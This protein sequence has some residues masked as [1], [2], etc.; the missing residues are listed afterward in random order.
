M[1]LECYLIGIKVTFEDGKFGLDLS[2]CEASMPEP[3][4][5][6]PI[7]FG[8]IKLSVRALYDDGQMINS[9]VIIHVTNGCL[10]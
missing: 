9:K 5:F 4:Q 3:K 6:G 10:G 7:K 2:C 1:I 8:P